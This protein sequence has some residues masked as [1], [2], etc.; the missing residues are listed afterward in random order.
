[1]RYSMRYSHRFS[2]AAAGCI[3]LIAGC[4]QVSTSKSDFDI[5]QAGQPIPLLTTQA[6]SVQ[7]RLELGL[8]TQSLSEMQI[9][10]LQANDL[11]GYP[12][13]NITFTA[14]VDMSDVWK[15]GAE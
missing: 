14:P 3:L 11:E 1:M 4:N 15:L 8:S 12:F 6:L 2:A 5:L 9:Q 10:T 7:D 13:V